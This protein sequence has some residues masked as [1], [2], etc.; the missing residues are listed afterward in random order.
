M[1]MRSLIDF[2]LNDKI[3]DT[4]GFL[5]KLKEVRKDN[6]ISNQQYDILLSTVEI[7]HSVVHRENNLNKEDTLELMSVIESIFNQEIQSG[8]IKKIESRLSKK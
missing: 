3:G 5:K 8:K 4:G 2:Y 7:G 6:I 1:G